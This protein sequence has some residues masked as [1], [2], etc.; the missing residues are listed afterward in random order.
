MQIRTSEHSNWQ[1]ALKEPPPYFQLI[2]FRLGSIQAD[3]EAPSLGSK[4]Q[5]RAD[6]LRTSASVLAPSPLPLY[7]FSLR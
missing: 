3:P 2:K 5:L 1:L 7:C 6:R 4:P